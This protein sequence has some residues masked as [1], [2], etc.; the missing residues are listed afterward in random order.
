[1]RLSWWISIAVIV[2]LIGLYVWLFFYTR[3]RQKAFDAQYTAAKERHEVFVLNKKI[4]KERSQNKWMRFAKFKT[5][6]VIGRVSLSQKVK[7]V[8]MSRMQTVTFQTTKSEYAK[9]Q[10][11]HKYRVDIAGNYIG[12]V[13]SPVGKPKGKAAATATAATKKPSL[14]ARFRKN[15]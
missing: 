11:N 5:Y 3:K 7:G 12:F 10:P 4:S 15:R 1:M 13:H 8:Q 14:L 2:I 9:I 6:Q